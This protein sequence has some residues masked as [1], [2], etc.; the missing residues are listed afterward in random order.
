MSDG[1][2]RMQA[3]PA[4]T[5]AELLNKLT[6]PTAEL[7]HFVSSLRTVNLMW[8]GHVH[9]ERLQLGA[10]FTSQAGSHGTLKP[11]R[12]SFAEQSS[13]R[14]PARNACSPADKIE[15][16]SKLLSVWFDLTPLSQL[17]GVGGGLQKAKRR[18][19]QYSERFVFIEQP[20]DR[21]HLSDGILAGRTRRGPGA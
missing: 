11:C 2:H 5:E 17:R 21:Y 16:W 7:L 1:R 4:T 3:G 19:L 14:E 12:R 20:H 9:R 15:C 6:R 13:W 10:C 8:P 18:R